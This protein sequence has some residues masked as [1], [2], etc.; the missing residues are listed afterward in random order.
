MDILESQALVQVRK[1]RTDLE[2]VSSEY[3]QME[4]ILHTFRVKLNKA[5]LAYD[6]AYRLLEK[7]RLVGRKVA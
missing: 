6:D 5:R 4:A 1:A 2:Q 3:D 7:A